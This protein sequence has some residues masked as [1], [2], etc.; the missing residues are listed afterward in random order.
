[1]CAS[2]IGVFSRF[3]TVYAKRAAISSQRHAAVQYA[4]GSL[5]A[6]PFLALSF[7]LF[8]CR[9]FCKFSHLFSLLLVWISA[10]A[11]GR[12]SSKNAIDNL[13]INE[14]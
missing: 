4:L 13:R 10:K 14:A 6:F 2:E 3:M 8:C 7:V 12:V 1:M 11:F 5:F 9:V